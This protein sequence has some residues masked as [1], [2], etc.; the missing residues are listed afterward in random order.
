MLSLYRPVLDLPGA[1]PL[2][3]WSLLSRTVSI[4]QG[5]IV[6]IAAYGATGSWLWASV[7]AS[8]N[9]GCAALSAWIMG[10]LMDRFPVR[11]ILLITSPGALMLLPLGLVEAGVTVTCLIALTAGL[12]RPA[13][14][15]ALRTVWTSLCSDQQSRAAAFSMEASIV[16]IAGALGAAGAGLVAETWGASQVAIPA[17]IIGF[18]ATLGLALCRA[19]KQAPVPQRKAGQQ[20]KV[21]LGAATWAAILAVAASWFALS[22]AEVGVGSARGAGQLGYLTGLS[23][24]AVVLGAHLYASRGGTGQPLKWITGGLAASAFSLLLLSGSVQWLLPA[25]CLMFALGAGRGVLSPSISSSIA[26]W[27]PSARQSEAM[28]LYGTAVLV[29]QT[30]SRPLAGLLAHNL[31][32]GWP[33][34]MAAVA[35]A[36][37]AV[38]VWRQARGQNREVR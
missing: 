18:L 30:A 16:P 20:I 19:V 1:K 2:L 34:L 5:A 25:A 35:S 21:P 31:G 37:V 12:M 24:L 4:P 9:T 3:G 33:I 8:I 13:G 32:P 17:A 7:A 10:Q 14:G 26:Q 11:K 29:G 6:L 28:G 27:A 22:A 38:I 36:L 23:M 15:T